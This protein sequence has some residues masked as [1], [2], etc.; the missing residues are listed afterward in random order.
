MDNHPKILSN[1][2]RAPRAP[3][4]STAS[5]ISTPGPVLHDISHVYCE[6]LSDHYSSNAF[7]VNYSQQITNGMN[8]AYVR[9]LPA[10]YLKHWGLLVGGH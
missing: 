3:T 2:T 1:E 4:P 8:P 5:Y 7:E 10:H 6:E 9:E